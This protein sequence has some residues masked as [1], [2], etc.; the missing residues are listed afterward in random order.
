[1]L[2]EQG[3]LL[4]AEVIPELLVPVRP[5]KA[6]QRAV[7]P[8]ADVLVKPLPRDGL[9]ALVPLRAPDSLLI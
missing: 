9:P 2:A 3:L 6:P 4:V 8:A 5:Q 7:V 1:M